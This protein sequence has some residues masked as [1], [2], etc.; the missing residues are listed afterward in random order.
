MDE[1]LNAG[2]LDSVS[3]AAKEGLEETNINTTNISP[4]EAEMKPPPENVLFVGNLCHNTTDDELLHLIFSRYGTVKSTCII[5]DGYTEESSCNAFIE[6][7]TE[8][9]CEQSYYGNKIS[10]IDGY[11]IRLEYHTFS[12]AVAKLWPNYTEQRGSSPI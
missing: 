10:E 5:R 9:V 6:F 12:H 2:E 8:E 11:K 1:D 7:E 3:H 4:Y